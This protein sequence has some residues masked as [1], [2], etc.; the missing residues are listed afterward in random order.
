MK[1]YF[2][3]LAMTLMCCVGTFAQSGTFSKV[4]TTSPALGANSDSLAVWNGATKEIRYLP[5]SNFLNVV[6]LDTLRKI[7]FHEGTEDVIE[8]N[9]TAYFNNNGRYILDYTDRKVDSVFVLPGVDG[10]KYVKQFHG[11]PD[12]SFFPKLKMPNDTLAPLYNGSIIL[13]DFRGIVLAKQSA[14]KELSIGF[15]GSSICAGSLFDGA[16]AI[17][18]E[19]NGIYNYSGQ[20]IASLAIVTQDQNFIAVDSTKYPVVKPFN[21]NVKSVPSVVQRLPIPVHCLLANTSPNFT[22][23]FKQYYYTL[24][25]SLTIY[26]LVR[27]NAQSQSFNVTTSL[28]TTTINT[29]EPPVVY[30]GTSYNKALTL[31]KKVIPIPAT[32]TVSVTI[33]GLTGSGTDFAC[34]AGFSF[35]SGVEVHNW[36]VSSSSLKNNSSYNALRGITTDERMDSLFKYKPDV[37]ML[38]WVDS[39]DSLSVSPEQYGFD[40]TRRVRQCRAENPRSAIVL[41]SNPRATVADTV[42]RAAIPIYNNIMRRVALREKTSFIDIERI[43]Q[44]FPEL[45]YDDI[46]PNPTGYMLIGNYIATQFGFKPLKFTDGPERN[47]LQVNDTRVINASPALAQAA[48]A[49]V[50]SY[51]RADNT[52][53]SGSAAKYVIGE[54]TT[55]GTAESTI[56]GRSN[57]AGTDLQGIAY[58]RNATSDYSLILFGYDGARKNG[59]EITKGGFI[60][61]HQAP[62]TVTSTHEFLVRDIT[63]GAIQKV[64]SNLFGY[65]ASAQTWAG[66]N[67][68][69]QSPIVPNPTTTLQAANKSYVDAYGFTVDATTTAYDNT[70]LN[71]TYGSVGVGHR[72]ICKDIVAG[73]V[74]YTK[75]TEAGSSDVWIYS[76]QIIVP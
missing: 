6:Q 33:S 76:A 20:M 14:G 56:V 26:Y 19:T 23:N 10:K 74:I 69:S 51:F 27:S 46:H 34:I 31:R 21:G 68:F 42:G 39:R 17:M 15:N 36:G 58:K 70:G 52:A 37:I 32:K 57:S 64:A 12:V 54:V 8:V 2:Y 43:M 72:V 35:G 41:I 55:S 5:K 62:P 61:Y 40:L 28:G 45:Y 38:Q 65:L 7:Y 67:T 47:Y 66:I 13:D 18:G 44:D 30:N 4:K 24:R 63:T 22:Y 49:W 25:D 73:P 1:K 60:I 50:S 3:L 71:A 75:V 48:F 53:T 29:Y 59:L 16:S 9:D 11:T